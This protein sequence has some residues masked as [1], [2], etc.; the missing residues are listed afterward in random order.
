MEESGSNTKIG[1]TMLGTFAD[2]TSVQSPHTF[3][4][5]HSPTQMDQL[6][7]QLSKASILQGEKSNQKLET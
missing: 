2:K 4:L 5:A 7:T 1:S 3:S 6:N